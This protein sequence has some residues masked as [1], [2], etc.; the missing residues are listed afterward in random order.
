[1]SK[2]N[3]SL[4][5]SAQLAKIC[6][7]SQG[8]VDRALNNRPGINAQT[9]KKILEAA[10]TYGYSPN[11]FTNIP[12]S[13]KSQLFGVVLFDLNNDY[14]SRFIMD[15]EVLCQRIG[16]NSVVMF[17]HN[18]RKTEIGC[19]NQL[20]HLGV[21]GIVLCPVGRGEEYMLYLKS[22][23]LPIVTIGNRIEGIPFVGLNDHSA[24][25]GMTKHAISLGYKDFI[26]YAPVLKKDGYENIYAQNERYS[27]FLNAVEKYGYPYKT[28]LSEDELKSML[29][30]DVQ[31]AIICPSDIY[32][33]A[34]YN[35][36]RE[37]GFSDVKVFGFDNC[38]MLDK[39]RIKVDSVTYDRNNLI[40]QIYRFLN[41]TQSDEVIYIPHNIAVRK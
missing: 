3:Y 5:T 27:G 23:N 31:R 21:D 18:D 16:Y 9:K 30:D 41:G 14:F 19:I 7:V 15:F 29:K 13:N 37:K 10:R 36:I 4:I 8:T 11:V 12:L 20:V 34:T 2:N 28:A 6:N 39:A 25:R 1:M 33:I 17:S 35:L 26:Y 32:A 22:L 40:E 24:M 38:D